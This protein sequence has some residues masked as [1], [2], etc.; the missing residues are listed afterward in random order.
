MQEDAENRTG[1]EI[2]PLAS[3]AQ[4]QIPMIAI[5]EILALII[6]VIARLWSCVAGISFNAPSK[7]LILPERRLVVTPHKSACPRAAFV[8]LAITVS[9]ESG[10]APQ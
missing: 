9:G 5:S 4:H 1:S 6:A 7:K 2:Q 10:G 8:F 3:V